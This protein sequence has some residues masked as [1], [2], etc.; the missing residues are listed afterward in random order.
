MRSEFREK[1]EN[2]NITPYKRSGLYYILRGYSSAYR[3]LL[4]DVL[5]VQP[6]LMILGKRYTTMATFNRNPATQDYVKKFFTL[7]DFAASIYNGHTFVECDNEDDDD[8]IVMYYSEYHAAR[9]LSKTFDCRKLGK[10]ADPD[11]K[12]AVSKCGNFPELLIHCEGQVSN[13]YGKVTRAY[14]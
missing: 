5:R 2:Q 6:Q 14:K 3:A 7:P 4:E 8:R 10:N 11:W 12:M 13:A 9:A 1:F